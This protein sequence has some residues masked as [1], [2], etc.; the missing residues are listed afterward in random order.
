MWPEDAESALALTF[1][2]D[3]EELWTRAGLTDRSQGT[4]GARVGVPHVLRILGLY[5]LPATFFVVGAVAERYPDTVRDIL[6]AG[7]E[8][9]LHG[10]SH[11]MPSELSDA[12]QLDELRR[13]RHSLEALDAEVLGYRAPGWGVTHY[14]MAVLHEEGFVYSSNLMDDVRPYRHEATGLIELPVHWSLDDAPFFWFDGRSW[15]RTITPPDQALAAWIGEAEGIHALGGCAVLT[16]HPQIVGRPG[17]LRRL[18]ELIR[19]LMRLGPWIAT[20]AQIAA[21][22]R[23]ESGPQD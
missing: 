13:G 15:E 3:A 20:C 2:F 22:V 6:A 19:R 18:E 9:A 7:H 1:D 23:R 10:Y 21:H 11:R 8:V 5:G 16:F 12:D 17:R 14:T 4:Y